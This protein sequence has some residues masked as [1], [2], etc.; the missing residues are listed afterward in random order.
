MKQVVLHLITLIVAGGISYFCITTFPENEI[1]PD[2]LCLSKTSGLY[3]NYDKGD[4][5]E[6][7]I[8]LNLSIKNN[9]LILGS[10]ELTGKDTSK[11]KP[12]HFIP[13][14]TYS[15]VLGM[16]H[17]G[18]Q[19]FA[20]FTQLLHYSQYLKDSKIIVVVSPGWFTNGY[21]KGTSIPSFLEYAN[22][23]FLLNIYRND[24]LN[25]TYKQALSDYI[26]RNYNDISS[27]SWVMKAFY[28]DRNEWS[29]I[30]NAPLSFINNLLLNSRK[31][32]TPVLPDNCNHTPKKDSLPSIKWDKLTAKSINDHTNQSTNNKWGINN[33]YYTN[34]T[35][36]KKAFQK[37]PEMNNNQELQD[38]RLLCQ[39]LHEYKADP[40]FIIQPLNPYA[41]ENLTDL[42]P[43][44]DS[45]ESISNRFNIPTFNMFI[46]DTAHYEK[47][48]LTDVMHLGDYGWL[49]INQK[50]INHYNIP[51]NESP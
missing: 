9:I 7:D 39:L 16:G 1:T 46:S 44:I 25:Y 20:I 48:M 45:I 28:Y 13:K 41:Y 22:E 50:I 4:Q 47:G 3:L 2:S 8:A 29:K 21:E 19:N 18:N 37:I 49:R 31:E 35:K 23:R 12:F 27:P 43:I 26:S 11:L 40:L 38:F 34:Y 10:S 5:A 6:A 33:D 42:T 36:G 17:A 14:H 32:I 24:S 30:K 51:Y 15:N